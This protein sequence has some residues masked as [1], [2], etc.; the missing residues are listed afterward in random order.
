MKSP[1]SSTAESEL[2]RLIE[3][4][5]KL[6]GP[7]GCPWD[8]EQTPQS[9]IPFLLEEAYE[10]VETLEDA[11]TEEL[12]KELGDLLL[13]IVMQAQMAEEKNTFKLRDSIFSINEKLIRRHPHVFGDN[14]SESKRMEDAKV[15][16]ERVKK[17]EG[18]K[19]WVDGVPKNLSG[20]VRAQRVQEKASNVG[21]DWDDVT[22]ALEK[23]HEEVDE[24]LEVW[25]QGDHDRS[26]E[27]FGDVLFSMVNIGR[28]MKIDSESSMRLAVD[29][30]D[31]RFRAVEAVF[32]QENRNIETASLTEM[33]EVWD[34][35]KHSV[36]FRK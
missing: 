35:I 5:A 33:D 16:W 24:L 25:K 9:M 2:T 27:E 10:V 30:F 19:S 20:L 21:F 4:V 15:N 36:E 3:I 32:E 31:A 14:L 23:C 6:R 1:I 28:L 13:H 26:R 18:R 12:Q 34:R 22:P 7:E 17:S 8:R 29:K 11:N